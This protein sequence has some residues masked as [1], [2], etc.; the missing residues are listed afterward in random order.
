MRDES[1]N[2][3]LKTLEEPPEFAH[4]ILLSSEPEALLETIASR[5][6]PVEFAPLS[7]EVLRSRSLPPTPP[8]MGR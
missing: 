2:A 5:C 7:A 1:Q 8:P 4:L 6:Q 3:L